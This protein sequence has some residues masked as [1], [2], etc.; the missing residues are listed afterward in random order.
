[1][2]HLPITRDSELTARSSNMRFTL[3][4]QLLGGIGASWMEQ[5]PVDETGEGKTLRLQLLARYAL[6][7]MLTRREFML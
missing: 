6:N 3:H 5:L 4:V 2:I 7:A 1:M